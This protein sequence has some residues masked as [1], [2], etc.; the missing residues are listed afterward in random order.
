MPVPKNK[1]K[2]DHA[3]GHLGVYYH[4]EPRVSRLGEWW[5]RAVDAQVG[6]GQEVPPKEVKA[7]F[8]IWPAEQNIE[9]NIIVEIQ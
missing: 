4:S 2:T 6:A 5:V 8:Q 9:D 1:K 3:C 7:Y